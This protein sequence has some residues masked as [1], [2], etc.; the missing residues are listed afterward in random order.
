M[1]FIFPRAALGA[2]LP[3]L[4]LGGLLYCHYT[5]ARALV[6]LLLAAAV[7]AGADYHD[8]EQAAL[9]LAIPLL[10]LNFLFTFATRRAVW[11]AVGLWLAAQAITQAAL[12][13]QDRLLAS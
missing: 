6:A 5:L 13:L 10:L 8:A 4:R 3:W 1:T 9:L 11:L 7:S 2:S 12:L